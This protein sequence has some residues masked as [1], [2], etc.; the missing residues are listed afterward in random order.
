MVSFREWL[1]EWANY[2]LTTEITEFTEILKGF[3]R[4]LSVLRG[5][6]VRLAH[7]IIH[8]YH[9]IKFYRIENRRYNMSVQLISRETDKE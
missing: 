8:S 4:V 5:E 9:F 1:K 2:L 3:L 6:T 7:T